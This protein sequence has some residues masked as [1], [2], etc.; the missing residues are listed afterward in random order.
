LI[1]PLAVLLPT[2]TSGQGQQGSGSPYSAYGLGSLMGSTQASQ[3]MMGGAGVALYDPFSVIQINP[4]S[5]ASLSRPAFETAVVIRAQQFRS[6]DISQSGQ[7]TDLLGLTF[8]VPFGNGRWGLALGLNPVSSVRYTISDSRPLGS[9]GETVDFEYSGSGGLNRA[10]IGS[11]HSI[12]FKRDSLGNGSTLSFGANFNYDFGTVDE[13]RKAYYPRS[14]GY[15]NTLVVNSL[16]LNGL[17]AGLGA[18]FQGDI[19]PKTTRTDKGLRYMIG[20]S[21]E[22][23]TNLGAQRSGSISTFILGGSGVE[24]PLDTVS[25]TTGTKGSMGLPPLYVV[26]F[27]V[28]NAQWA[29]T[30]EHRRRDWSQLRVD[31][32]GLDLHSDLGVNASYIVGGSYRPA[33]DG[34]G[35]FWTS[36][37]Y[38]AGFRFSDDYLVV[39]ERQLQEIGMSFGMSLPLMGSTT[40]SRLNLGAE[41]G[42]NGSREEG[43]IE[44]RFAH[45]FI[46]LTITPDLR[47]QWFKKRRIE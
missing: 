1:L 38:R 16:S 44:Q 39:G 12:P 9:A 6:G 26:G 41:L 7:R 34:R 18:R 13:V 22:L 11:A 15:V 36:T 43:L 8:G 10:F 4:A 2:A 42:R 33:G 23:P 47:E 31:V 46:G 3:A 14:T 29:A 30:V 5:Y 19:K 32:E 24:F 45:F 20:A 40:R 25:G 37:I 28:F 35:T 27:T 21:M 17:V